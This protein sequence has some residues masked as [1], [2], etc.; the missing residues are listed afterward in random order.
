MKL[1]WTPKVLRGFL[2]LFQDSPFLFFLWVVACETFSIPFRVLILL[3]LM[4]IITKWITLRFRDLSY[5]L[6]KC[7]LPVFT[8][9]C[10][11]CV[12]PSAHPQILLLPL[13]C[14]CVRWNR[15]LIV[16]LL[17]SLWK[18]RPDPSYFR[19]FSSSYMLSRRRKRVGMTVGPFIL[20]LRFFKK[21][22]MVTA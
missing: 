17:A 7:T 20:F 21:R 1:L 10:K 5:G 9:S 18:V 14:V 22:H 2:A 15:F 3:T 8:F 6:L 19:L 11:F 13:S 16:S 12:P 4:F